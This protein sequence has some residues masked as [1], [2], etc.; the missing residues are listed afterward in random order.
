VS[1]SVKALEELDEIIP[2]ARR[3]GLG[4][5]ASGMRDGDA[6]PFQAG[7]AVG[8]GSEMKLEASTLSLAE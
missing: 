8:T 6:K 7:G 3:Q 1:V 2:G 5:D 4:I